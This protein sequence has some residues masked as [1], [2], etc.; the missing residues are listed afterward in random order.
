MIRLTRNSP[1]VPIG[2]ISCTSRQNELKK[3]PFRTRQADK[4]GQN[5]HGH[6]QTSKKSPKTLPNCLFFPQKHVLSG[7]KIDVFPLKP[8]LVPSTVFLASSK[9]VIF[10]ENWLGISTLPALADYLFGLVV[11]PRQSCQFFL[12][13]I[14]FW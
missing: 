11:T 5:L 1:N 13:T 10:Y 3:P 7:E 9:F 2:L 6:G 8:L 4:N 14:L 12:K